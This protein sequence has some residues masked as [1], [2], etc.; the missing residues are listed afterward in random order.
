MKYED[1]LGFDEDPPLNGAQNAEAPLDGMRLLEILDAVEKKKRGARPGDIKL[2]PGKLPYVADQADQLLAIEGSTYKRGVLLVRVARLGPETPAALSRAWK[3]RNSGG[4]DPDSPAII[5]HDSSSLRD[6]LTRAADTHDRNFVSYDGRKKD[7]KPVDC[8]HEVATTL[9]SRAGRWTVPVL[10]GFVAAPTL[11]PD[12]SILQTPGYDPATGLLAVFKENEFPP[13]PERPSKDAARRALDLIADIFRQF[14]YIDEASRSVA[15][16]AVL[17]ALIRPSLET[18]PIHA[19]TA[20]RPRSG[21]S[22]QP[23]IA[24]LISTGRLPAIVT[25]NEDA[26]EEKKRLLSL[27]IAGEPI[28]SIDNVDAPL[29]SEALCSV[30]TE[31]E[32]QDR[33]L[34]VSKQ[35]KVSCS[36]LFCI[37]GNNLVLKGDLNDRS[38]IAVIDPATDR[39]EER[40]FEQPRLEEEVRERRRELAIAGLTVLRAYV[41]AGGPDVGIKEWGGFEQWSAW[42]RSALVW[43]GCADPRATRVHLEKNDPA[44]NQLI[45][46]LSAW[47]EVLRDA[48]CTTAQVINAANE[49][50]TL[51][52]GFH[53]TEIHPKHQDLHDAVSAV[54]VGASGAN[55]LG[56]F[57]SKFVD[58]VE[59]GLVLRRIAPDSHRKVVRW[60]VGVSK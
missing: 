48:P 51:E 3:A 16:S 58:R 22:K 40:T 35:V 32:W 54:A 6:T 45:A 2:L 14:P 19:F 41:V 46:L 57:L 4:A 39:P 31:G 21:K 20:P 44:R 9:L 33:L 17:T 37:N 25:P 49:T 56:N 47:Y 30:V 55:R 1:G 5:P 24:S 7:W 29:W 59:G 18:A 8:P 60:S 28:I 34:G 42:P 15:Y 43:L 27:L 52:T 26:T 38:V 53:R 13:I 12:G 23:R 50:T 36:S 10:T 11:R